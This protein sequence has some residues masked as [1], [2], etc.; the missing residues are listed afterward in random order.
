M[1]GSSADAGSR[2][3]A[4][5]DAVSRATKLGINPGG[6]AMIVPCPANLVPKE[7]TNRLLNLAELSTI[8]LMAHVPTS[9][10]RGVY[11]PPDTSYID[12]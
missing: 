6:Q 10:D 4:S 2:G 5:D 12:Q 8:T 1:K 3:L 9:E 11:P 7:C